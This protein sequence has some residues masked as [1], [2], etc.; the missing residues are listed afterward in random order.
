MREMY[1]IIIDMEYSHRRDSKLRS[2]NTGT[3]ALDAEI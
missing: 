2:G 1:N 3:P